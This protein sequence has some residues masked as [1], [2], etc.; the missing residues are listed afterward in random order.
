MYIEDKKKNEQLNNNNYFQ[1]GSILNFFF[2]YKRI[3][4]FVFCFLEQG[5]FE[6]Q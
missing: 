6:V 2:K 5:S 3:L 4:R 1:S